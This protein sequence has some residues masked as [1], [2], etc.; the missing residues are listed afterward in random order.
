MEMLYSLVPF[1]FY[2]PRMFLYL[3]PRQKWRQNMQQSFDI[4]CCIT[5]A[6]VLLVGSWVGPEP[7]WTQYPSREFNPSSSNLHPLALSLC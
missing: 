1:P 2:K 4:H 7:V 6:F 5:S 3:K